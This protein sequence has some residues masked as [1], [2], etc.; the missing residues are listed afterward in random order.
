MDCL[1]PVELIVG[2][3][4][5]GAQYAAS[6]H[7]VGFMV[8]E[9]MARHWQTELRADKK[10]FYSRW[11]EARLGSRKILMA[12]PQTY[13]NLSGEAVS[14]L[15]NYFD[16]APAA[17]AVVYDDM[18]LDFGRLKVNVN[19]GSGGHKGVASITDHLDTEEF[20]R[21][22]VG[23]GRPRFAEPAERYV[24]GNFYPDQQDGLEAML[25][26]ATRCLLAIVEAGAEAAMR[27]F[28]RN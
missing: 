13:M 11:G 20:V 2:L 4:N 7:N 6:R 23:I 10:K 14:A 16:I 18:D 25:E 3:G 9:S 12:L 22:R 15:A 26:Q 5:P 17:I 27:E 28:N 24:L 8:V 1:P 19:R 21:L